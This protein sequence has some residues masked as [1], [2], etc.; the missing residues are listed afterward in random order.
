[1]ASNEAVRDQLSE[2]W[3]KQIAAYD[4]VQFYDEEDIQDILAKI[5]EPTAEGSV[6]SDGHAG[7]SSMSS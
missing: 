5:Y 3:R 4:D 6:G 1:M 7:E 2:W